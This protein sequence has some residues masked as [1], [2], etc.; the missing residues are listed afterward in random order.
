MPTTLHDKIAFMDQIVS[1]CRFRAGIKQDD[2]IRQRELEI[3][4]SI[5]DDCRAQEAASI[6]AHRASA[7]SLGE[8][9]H[10]INGG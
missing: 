6:R 4:S 1:K 3:A 9:A 8:L 7:E 5:L 2:V 10:R